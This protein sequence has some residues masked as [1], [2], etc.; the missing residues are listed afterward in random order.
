TIYPRAKQFLMAEGRTAEQVEAMP[1][2]QAVVMFEIHNYDRLFDDMLKW[3]TLPF[4]E[5]RAGL[6]RAEQQ[7]KQE[8]IKGPGAGSTLATLLL[9]AIY[10]V[11]EASARSER[12]LAMLRTIEA[13]RLYAA[14]HE[15]KLPAALSDIRAVPLP[16]DPYTGKPFDYLA[17]GDKATLHG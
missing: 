17:N 15:G 14:G 16:A 3:M 8:K 10:K 12:R 9:P 4:P 1:M 5:S 2:M 6:Q 7:L 11:N 13:L